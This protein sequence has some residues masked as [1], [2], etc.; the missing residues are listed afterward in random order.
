MI[1]LLAA[2]LAVTQVPTDPEKGYLMFFTKGEVAAPA[3]PAVSAEMMKG[4][5]GNMTRLYKE[6][7]LTAAGPLKD[8]SGK[9]RGLTVVWAKHYSEVDK[10]FEEDPFVKAGMMKVTHL[11]WSVKRSQFG[12]PHETE[13][14]E[15]R[16]VIF[17]RQDNEKPVTNI[18]RAV[19]YESH[20]AALTAMLK[21]IGPNIYAPMNAKSTHWETLIIASKDDQLIR[22]KVSALPLVQAGRYTFEIFPL[23]MGKGTVPGS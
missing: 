5:L 17:Y 20:P 16:M 3:D 9:I 4:H 19:A 14:A 11:E 2:T 22:K 8:P 18:D 13:I 12:K 23:W 6:G 1:P 15:H 7:K 10:M 21:D